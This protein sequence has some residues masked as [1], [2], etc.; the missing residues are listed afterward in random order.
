MTINQSAIGTRTDPVTVLIER[1]RLRLFA[2]ATGQV[3]PV[4]TDVDAARAAGHRDLVVPPTFLFGLELERPEPF[5]WMTS[6]G[7]DMA[8]VLH[9]TQSFTYDALAYAG[10]ELTATSTITDVFSKK[11]GALDFVVRDTEVSRAGERIAALVQTTV[12]RVRVPA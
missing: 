6:L 12:V 5:A 11:G 3:D 4:Y 8:D 2:K 10:D 1:G 7:I 9:G